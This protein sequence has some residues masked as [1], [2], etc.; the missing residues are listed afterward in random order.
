M[1]YTDEQIGRLLDT[2]RSHSPRAA[3]AVAGMPPL[4]GFP[5]LP[6]PLRATFGMRGRS[7]DEVARQVVA[8]RPNVIHVPVD[9]DP[10]PQKFAL[11]GYHPSEESY[12]EFGTHMAAGLLNGRPLTS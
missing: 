12:A 6:Q 8:R 4:H 1:A 3:I 7:F 11:D 10:D 5:L 9:V 2:L